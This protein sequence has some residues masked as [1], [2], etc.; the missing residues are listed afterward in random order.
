MSTE[1]ENVINDLLT[2][3]VQKNAQD[4]IAYLKANEMTVASEVSYNGKSI[5]Y[6]H[7][8]GQEGY[9]SP[10]TIWTDGDYSWEYEEVPMDEHMKKIAW[11][12]VNTCAGENCPGKCHPGKS[13]VILGKEFDN[14]CNADMAFHVPDAETLACVK[15]L[16]EMRKVDALKVENELKKVLSGETLENALDFVAF[17]REAGMTTHPDNPNRFCYMGK[18][19]CILVFFEHENFPSGLWVICDCPIDGHDGFPIDESLKEFARANVKVC[20]KCCGCPVPRGGDKRI[21]GKEY[22]GVCSSEIQF[23]N[24]DAKALEKIKVLMELWK[25]Q[26]ADIKK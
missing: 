1:I 22:K 7:L 12:H 23:V 11:A 10:W 4:F 18:E 19:T 6:M 14:V 26:I 24:P 20:D 15:K 17:L 8:D 9:P 5:C 3:D 21:W 25:H 16:L 2:G 13:K